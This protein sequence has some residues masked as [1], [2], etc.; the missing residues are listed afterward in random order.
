M[1]KATGKPFITQSEAYKKYE[2]Q[3]GWFLKPVPSKPIDIPINICYRF[4][5]PKNTKTD[6]SN[7]I[8]AVDDILVRYKI[9]ADDNHR[10]VAGHDGT[11]VYVDKNNPR[12]EITITRISEE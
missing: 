6:A 4:Y 3:A 8:E 1:N 10:I 5:L 11:R 7:L 12:T 9:I 2:S